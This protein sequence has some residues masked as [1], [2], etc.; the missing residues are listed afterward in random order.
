MANIIVLGAGLVGGVIAKDLAKQ[1]NVTSVDI[2]KK[3]L[4]KLEGINTI[5]TDIADTT[6]LK[7]LIKEFDLVVGAV[8]G[9]MGYK[10]MK[11]VIEEG[12]NI[13]DISFYPEDPFGLDKLAKE[14]GVVAVMD[15]GV[16]PGMGNVIFGYHNQTM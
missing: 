4:D 14:K 5:C 2:S 10:M 12:K 7:K 1:H 16:A 3:N 13:V 9:F 15:C 8:P 6:T 11:D